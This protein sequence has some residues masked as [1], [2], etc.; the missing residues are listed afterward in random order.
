MRNRET[1]GQKER[2]RGR[3]NCFRHEAKNKSHLTINCRRV[4]THL[5]R[6]WSSNHACSSFSHIELA[7]GEEHDGEEQPNQT[8]A[9]ERWK[10]HTLQFFFDGRA[11]AKKE[12]TRLDDPIVSCHRIP[13]DRD[14]TF[15]L[16]RARRNTN[17]ISLCF[18]LFFSD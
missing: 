2:E 8:R 5:F 16:A 11:L 13:N 1:E 9:G 14:G 15:V 12:E 4:S 6:R 18:F 10:T 7:E 3:D 17:R